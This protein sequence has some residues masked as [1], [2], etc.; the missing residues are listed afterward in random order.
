M[1]QY[2]LGIINACIFTTS[3]IMLYISADLLIH[4]NQVVI[5]FCNIMENSTYDETEQQAKHN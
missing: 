3:L 4:T 2:L 5:N 1:K